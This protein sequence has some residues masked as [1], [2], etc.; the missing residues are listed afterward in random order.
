MESTMTEGRVLSGIEFARAGDDGSRPLLLD[1]YLPGPKDGAAPRPA[2]V[3][4]HGGGWRMGERSSLGPVTDAFALTPFERLA[5]ASPHVII[6]TLAE[7][8]AVLSALVG[9][10]GRG[11][12]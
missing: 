9:P 4:F 5:A 8:P 6:E 1:L 12:R 11:S 2:V 7:L 10:P 3:H